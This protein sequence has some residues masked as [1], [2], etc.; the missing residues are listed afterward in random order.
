MTNSSYIAEAIKQRVTMLDAIRMYAPSP[1][2]Q[3][4][5]IPCP[6]HAG[7]HPNLS[8][9]DKLYHC[10]TCNSGGD[11]IHFVQH[12]FGLSFPDALAKINDDFSLSLPI[13]RRPTLSEQHAA[14]N[15]HNEIMAEKAKQTLAKQEYD[16]RSDALWNEYARLDRNRVNYAPTSSTGDVN[17][18]YIESLQKIDYQNYLLDTF[19]A[20]G[21]KV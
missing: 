16:A 10:H 6:I 13:S 15:R 5:R 3:H 11:M 14:Q 19:L 20:E 1:A 4:N 7:T 9:T 12:I 8:F 17:F 21:A 18:L 2:P